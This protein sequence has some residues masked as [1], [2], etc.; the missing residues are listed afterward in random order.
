MTDLS[1]VAPEL[2]IAYRPLGE[3]VLLTPTASTTYR[4]QIQL[5][6]SAGPTQA[7]AWKIIAMGPGR[8]HPETGAI[9]DTMTPSGLAVGDVVLVYPGT[10]YAQNFRENGR[11][12]V[13]IPIIGIQAVRRE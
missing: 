7:R 10:V 4:G 12:Y 9:I 5:P 1:L 13:L 2:D 8:T 11:E 3:M 6:D